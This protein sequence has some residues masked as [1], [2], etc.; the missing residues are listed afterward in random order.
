MQTK[1]EN[2]MTWKEL[3]SYCKSLNKEDLDKPALISA[4]KNAIDMF[5]LKRDENLDNI[6]YIETTND[7]CWRQDKKEAKDKFSIEN[8][9]ILL[10]I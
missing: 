8:P 2:T 1:F 6:P 10:L 3:L 5:G 4:S 7:V 9:K